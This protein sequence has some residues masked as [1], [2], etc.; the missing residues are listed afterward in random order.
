MRKL[1]SLLFFISFFVFHAGAQTKVKAGDLIFQNI[2]CGDMCDA[3]NAVTKGFEDHKFNHVGIVYLRNDSAFVIEAI[4]QDVHM[5]KLKQ[6]LSRTKAPHYIGRVKQDFEQLVPAALEFSLK[7]IG[8]K[9]DDEFLY[10][11]GKYYCSE[12]IYDA[13]KAANN[14]KPFFELFPMTYKQPGSDTYFPVWVSYFK[15]LN[16]EI[17]EGKPGCNPGGMSLSDKVE[18]FKY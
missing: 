18:V 12:L 5:I 15:K 17:P 16:M 14:N 13:Y 4:G 3:I 10:D 1:L 9:Y 2:S 8:I 6:F 7:Q 11:N